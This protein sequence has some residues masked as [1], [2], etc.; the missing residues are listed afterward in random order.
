MS[1]F[2]TKK[3]LKKYNFRPVKYRGQNF[4]ISKKV[5]KK[6]IKVSRLNQSDTVLEVGAGLGFLTKELAKRAKRVI[7]VEID[8]NLT[9]ILKEEL[10]ETDNLKIINTDILKADIKNWGL[11]KEKYKVIA[12]LPYHITSRF[13]RQF[14]GEKIRPQEMI[15]MVQKEV[16]E[17]I[18]AL[19]GKMSLLSVSC[20]FYA[21]CQIAG[22]VGRKNFWPPPQVDS[23]I[24]KLKIR[25]FL[26]QNKLNFSSNKNAQINEQL[27][28]KIVKAGF[29]NKRKKLFN[30]LIKNFNNKEKIKKIFNQLKFKEGIRA[31]DL[32]MQDWL[33]LYFYM[34]AEKL[35]K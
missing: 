17:R 23:A 24:I 20:Q 3:I 4:L 15:L 13:L 21:D 6:I 26:E 28:F 22:W 19:P 18:T 16:A 30:N 5:L 8:K 33:N 11:K 27:F 9:A 25:N 12:N 35:I 2:L 29:S 7:A 32:G 1:L 14:L 31:Q 10:K 34:V